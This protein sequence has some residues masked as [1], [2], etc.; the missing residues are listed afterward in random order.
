[1]RTL[2]GSISH[3]DVGYA[4]EADLGEVLAN[5]CFQKVGLIPALI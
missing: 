5:G 3:A 4:D 1:L 2:S